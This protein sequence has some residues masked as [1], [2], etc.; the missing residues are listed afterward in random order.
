VG[1]YSVLVHSGQRSLPDLHSVA[2]SDM[3]AAAAIADELLVQSRS[4]VGVEV[5]C[6]GNRLYARGV[7]PVGESRRA[8]ALVEAV[9]SD[10]QAGPMRGQG[11]RQTGAASSACANM[12]T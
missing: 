1:A 4:G 2:A 8:I 3:L 6:D 5:V 12:R 7:V 9:A 10:A 11:I